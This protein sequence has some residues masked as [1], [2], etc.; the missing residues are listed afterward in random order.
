M[1][2]II[3]YISFFVKDHI[4]NCKYALVTCP[5]PE[6]GM[7][8]I[9]NELEYHLDSCPFKPLLCR[10][11]LSK[12]PSNKLIEHHNTTCPEY[13]I[14][15]T[16]GCNEKIPRKELG[17]HLE[18]HCTLQKRPCRFM[19]YGCHFKDSLDSLIAHYRAE[20][21]YHL[22][23]IEKALS[24]GTFSHN[25]PRK[26]SDTEDRLSSATQNQL[27]QHKNEITH[28]LN[29]ISD[30]LLKLELKVGELQDNYQE[31]VLLMQTLQAT[32]Y[33]GQFVWKI[34]CRSI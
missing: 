4:Y 19:K 18:R 20:P 13:K 28:K 14:S 2:I 16:A 23:L 27:T 29:P 26:L 6:C 10:W 31:L 1:F 11:C 30:G 24:E 22:G 5:N 32:S 34:P 17:D 8:M 3:I 33:N 9:R 12:V 7:Q 21:G 25:S 15:C